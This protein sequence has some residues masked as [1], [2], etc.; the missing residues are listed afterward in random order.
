MAR[1]QMPKRKVDIHNLP[2]NNIEPLEE[3]KTIAS[4]LSVKKRRPKSGFA[5]EVS[6]IGTMLYEDIILPGLKSS[7]SEFFT[8]AIEMFI[9]GSDGVG[10]GAPRRRRGYTDYSDIST[11]SRRG[12]ATPRRHRALNTA[13]DLDDIIYASRQDAAQVLAAM[14]DYIAEYGWV[15]VANLH[16]FS[17][18]STTVNQSRYGWDSVSGTK[19]IKGRDGWYLDL[20]EPMYDQ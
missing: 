3:D 14:H 18:I 19:P 4:A 17:G 13:M 2:A 12:A 9:F 5:Y 10:R 1:R 7:M 20:P 16:E 11:R 15:T 8:G 6:N